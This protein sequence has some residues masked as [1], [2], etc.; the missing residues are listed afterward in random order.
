MA[1]YVIEL[2][3][4]S[5]NLASWQMLTLDPTDA[6][7]ANPAGGHHAFEMS[8]SDFQAANLVTVGVAWVDCDVNKSNAII[9]VT[10]YVTVDMSS[11]FRRTALN[12]GGGRYV[13][14]SITVTGASNPIKTLGIGPMI[15]LRSSP[16]TGIVRKIMV[17]LVA[18]DLPG[19]SQ[20]IITPSRII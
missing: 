4:V 2:F 11:G 7:F 8:G 9:G 13:Y 12:N 19:G 17:G 14:D 1:S 6:G 3:S 10:K 16:R 5:D 20:L 15:D 18:Q